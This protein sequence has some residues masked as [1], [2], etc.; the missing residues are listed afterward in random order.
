MKLNEFEM[1]LYITIW[2][3]RSIDIKQDQCTN[4]T[5]VCW[6]R[7]EGKWLGNEMCRIWEGKSATFAEGKLVYSNHPIR[8]P[9]QYDSIVEYLSPVTATFMLPEEKL[10][11][12]A[13]KVCDQDCTVKYFHQI[14]PEIKNQIIPLKRNLL[15]SDLS[16]TFSCHLKVHK[17]CMSWI[18]HH[19][20]NFLYLTFKIISRIEVVD[21]FHEFTCKF[22]EF[23]DEFGKSKKIWWW[24]WTIFFSTGEKNDEISCNTWIEATFCMCHSVNSVNC[25]KIHQQVR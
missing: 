3:I 10:A 8:S 17:M 13:F 4:A 20:R 25:K 5:N 14:L 19:Q 1:L 6:K 11:K 24:T 22:E 7:Y 12:A 21:E 2:F 18:F 15:K 16:Y 9:I 23:K